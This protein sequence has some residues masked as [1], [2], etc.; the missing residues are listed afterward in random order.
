M[1]KKED[2]TE[3]WIVVDKCSGSLSVAKLLI[4]CVNKRQGNRQI[5]MKSFWNYQCHIPS[6]PITQTLV[7]FWISLFC[8]MWAL[9]P[10][11]TEGFQRVEWAPADEA[12]VARCPCVPCP[13]SLHPRQQHTAGPNDDSKAG[14]VWET[15][16]RKVTLV[17]LRKLLSYF[18]F[19][20]F[21]S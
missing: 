3:R 12:P 17:Y 20:Y 10:H 15:K 13:S 5:S 4:V 6:G 7:K 1:A 21:H 11:M 2:K 8:I 14:P 9:A 19:H 16:A 18:M